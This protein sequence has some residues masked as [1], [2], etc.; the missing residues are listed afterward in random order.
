[1]LSKKVMKTEAISSSNTSELCSFQDFSI[2]TFSKFL[3]FSFNPENLTLDN[4]TNDLGSRYLDPFQTKSL[5]DQVDCFPHEDDS[6]NVE[7]SYFCAPNG[8]SVRLIPKCT[9]M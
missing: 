3:L 6:K 8:T 7:I 5:Y 9:L 2:S 1:M 4:L